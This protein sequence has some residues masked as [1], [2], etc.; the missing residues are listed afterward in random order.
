MTDCIFCKIINKE[1]PAHVIDENE[2][3]IVF[4][5]LE[6]HPLII[7]KKHI[8][9]IYDMDEQIG[10]EV[11]KETIKMANAVKKGLGC[12][13]V[14]LVQANEAAG[15]Q[16]VF[17]FHMH[18]KPRWKNEVASGDKQLLVDKIKAAL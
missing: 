12:D 14:T 17:H 18:V 3:L 8:V 16:E 13:G 15:G 11:M 1:I 6:N 7:P 9:N 10:S 4:L 5:S 2:H